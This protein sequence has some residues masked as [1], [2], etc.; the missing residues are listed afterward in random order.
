M[1]ATTDPTSTGLR[2]RPRPQIIADRAERDTRGW[3]SWVTTTDHKKIGIMYLA[4]VLVFFVLGGVEALLMRTQL[5]IP[6][7]TLL[8]PERYNQILT[9]HG[10]TMIF[11][12]VVPL[13]AGFANYLVPLYCL[14]LRGT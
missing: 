3:V 8:T 1:A 13:W 6:D 9:M 5:A 11:L 7:N 2:A 10:T 14:R 4:T 12:V